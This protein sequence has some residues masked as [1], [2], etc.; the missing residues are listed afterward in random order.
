MNA[1]T[2]RAY[3]LIEYGEKTKP[4]GFRPWDVMRD[5]GWD[6]QQFAAAVRTVRKNSPEFGWTISCTPTPTGTGG[7]LYKLAKLPG[8]MREW[9]GRRFVSID[10]Q[11]QTVEASMTLAVMSSD[12]R[13]LEGRK[14]RKSLRT[15]KYLRAE[16][17]DYDV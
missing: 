16:L 14:A 11:L 12:G 10:S 1:D 3:R 4:N 7:W 8:E 6:Y 5:L 17:A 2:R 13:T 9:V 15:I